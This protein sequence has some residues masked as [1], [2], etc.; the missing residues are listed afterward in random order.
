MMNPITPKKNQLQLSRYHFQVG[1]IVR[2]LFLLILATGVNLPLH[3]QFGTPGSV[4]MPD[5]STEQMEVK[6]ENFSSFTVSTFGDLAKWKELNSPATYNHP[7]FGKLPF[8]APCSDCIEVLEKRTIDERYFVTP[9]NPS[10]FKI[11]KAAG[12]LHYEKNGQWLTIDQRLADLGNG[13]YEASHQWDPVGFETANRRSYVITPSGKIYF[14]QWKL[15]GINNGT[16]ELLADANWSS[17]TAGEDGIYITNIFPGIDAELEVMRGSVKTSFII[18]S[19]NFTSYEELIFKDDMGDDFSNLSFKNSTGQN[20]SVDDVVYKTNGTDV[21]EI[22]TAVAFPEDATKEEY[23]LLTYHLENNRLGIVV[24]TSLI[25]SNLPGRELII[26]PLVTSSNTLAMASITGSMY[27]ASCNFTNSCNYNL[28]VNTPANSTLTNVLWS[29]TYSAAGLCWLEDGAVRFTTG[30]CVSPGG[31]GFYWFCN[32]TGG[33]T[34]AGTNVPIFTDLSACLPAPSCAP[35]PVTFT[36]QFFR[37]CWGAAGCNSACIGAA[38][39][40][41][42]TIEGNTLQYQNTVSPMT[43]SANTICFGQTV[44]ASTL[45]Q[46]GVPGYNYNWSFS[47]SGVPSVGTGANATISFPAAGAYTLYSIVTD[48]CGQTSTSNQNITVNPAPVITAEPDLNFCTGDAVPLNSFVT[49]PAGATFTWTNTNTAIGLAASGTVSTPAFTATN[50]TAAPI[51]G[52]VTVTPTLAGCVGPTDVYTITVN[53]IPVITAEADQSFCA[54]VAVPLN[55][56]TSVPGGATFSWTNSNTAIGLAASG[57]GDIPA[58]TATNATAAP[59][60]A[61]ITIT[62][63]LGACIGANDVYTITINPSPTVNA[64]ADLTFC[65]GDAVPLNTIT[66]TPGGA[67]FNW[68]NSNTAIG[69]G[70]SGT[71]NIPA[72]TAANGTGAAITGTVSITP[73]LSG[74]SGA[75]EVYLITVNPVPTVTDP[76]DQTLCAN[77][78]TTAVNFTGSIAGTTFNWTNSNTAIGLAASGTGNIA[79]FNATN[80]GTTAIVSTVTVTPTLGTC[81]GTP[82]T[83]TYT[84]NPNPTFTLAFTDPSICGASDGTITISGLNNS[85]NYSVTYTDGVPVGPATIMSSGTGTIVLSGL[86]AGSYSNFIVSLNGCATTNATVITLLDPNPPTVGAG[87]DQTTCAS[88]SVTLTASNPD[89]AIISWDNGVTDGVPFSPVTTLTYTVTANLA[90]CISTDQVVVTVN[91]NPIIGAGT[92]Q[93]VCAGSA[94]TLTANNPNGAVLTWDNSVTNGVA[95]T[96]A[97]TLTYTVSGNLAGCITTDQVVVTVNPLPTFTVSSTNPTVCA[98]SDGTII[99]SGLLNSTNYSITY[100][101]GAP[102]GPAVM[103]SSGTGTITIT[104]LNAGSY[105]NFVVTLNGCTTTDASVITL[106]DPSAPNVGAGLDQ[107]VCAGASVT[108]T[109]NNPDGAVIS[110]DNS[111]N[112]GVAFSPATTLTYTVTANLAGCISTDQVLVTVNPLPVI[113]AGTDVSVCAGGSVT[114][115]A[116]NPNSAALVWT[117]GI[118]NGTPFTPVASGTYTVT[119]TLAGCSASDDVVVTVNPIPT[120][121]ANSS[122]GTTLC[123]GDNVTLTGG[124]ANSYTWTGGVTN[125]VSFVAATTTTYTVTGTSLSGCSNTATITLTVNNC[126]GPDAIIGTSGSPATICVNDCINFQDLSTGTNVDTWFWD[127]GI[128]GMTSNAQNPATMCYGIAGTYTISLTV[129]DDIGS[130]VAT[131]V[132]TVIECNP[133]QADFTLS[134]SSICLGDCVTLTDIS[135]ESPTSWSWDFGGAVSPNTSTD[136]NPTICPTVPGTYDIELTATNAYGTNTVTHTLIVNETPLV[137]AGYDTTIDMHT[138]GILDATVIPG[139]G[140]YVWTDD[141]NIECPTCENTIVWPVFTE[142]FTV[143]YTSAAGCVAS[144]SVLITVLF[145]DVVNVPNGFSPNGDNLNDILFVKGDGIVNMRFSIYNRYGQLVFQSDDQKIGWDGYLNG[146]PENPG[147]F[148]WYLEYSLVDGSSNSKKGNVTLLK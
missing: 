52:T 105:S 138:F 37:G 148:V 2:A 26:D 40:W 143:V 1:F 46:Y 125:G 110:W 141:E 83:F 126:T 10:E 76:T 124:G 146:R 109:A 79:A 41:T 106:I 119:G 82:Q 42:M 89:G 118:T 74:C 108:L 6:Q 102:V 48:A 136:Q 88:G 11:Q 133:P 68:T 78:N 73:T 44:N 117:G 25:A 8:N 103:T 14:N 33:G 94:V 30:G 57:T 137:S 66:S 54:G 45:G 24:P 47:P 112:D 135:T 72:F 130:D 18:K 16:E 35:V 100:T 67:T 28:T 55:T 107:T 58:F 115:T 90:G 56:I 39:P 53:P 4:K 31:A 134:D 63:T 98:T 64:E 29:F 12:A 34:C 85:T 128:L 71:G 121:T 77:T 43:V 51:S 81:S 95:F 49:V 23:E 123:I 5:G 92:D 69:L 15:Y 129:T 132:L 61:N 20:R 21:F 65:A 97:G 22:T 3:A 84:V 86:N 7:E 19:A 144:D 62:P 139:G 104:G 96:P 75:A 27:N 9:E 99:L 93:T 140:S 111:V 50:A 70:A 114:L 13:N 145:E 60:T 38:T 32:L 127:F 36:M 147:V 87:V 142:Q 59:I 17:Y 131:F 113:G 91:P 120:V 101:D 116:N 122:A 80:P